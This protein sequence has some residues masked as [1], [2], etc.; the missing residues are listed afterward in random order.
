M[1]EEVAAYRKLAPCERRFVRLYMK[2]HCNGTHTML[3]MR[4]H[5]KPESAKR[6]GSRFRNRPHVARA[7]EAAIDREFEAFKDS[8]LELAHQVNQRANF[9]RTELLQQESGAGAKLTLKPLDKWPAGARAV[10]ESLEFE[11]GVL[12]KVR[13]S[14]RNEASRL[15]AQILRMLRETHE[16]TGK[17]G[18]PLPPSTVVYVVEKDEAKQIGAQLDA[19]I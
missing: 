11:N 12:T 15:E 14:S 8:R 16:H 6:M 3:E 7:I 18:A 1:G 17:D 9:D 2:N 5:L 13:T 4:P 19:E 10:V